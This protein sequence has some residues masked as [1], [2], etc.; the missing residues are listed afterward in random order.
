M[1]ID[2]K[3][4]PRLELRVHQIKM[5]ILR[6]DA[7]SATPPL[8]AVKLVMNL[9]MTEIKQSK[10]CK[11]KFIAISRAQPHSPSRRRVF[12][13]LLPVRKRSDLCGLLLKSKCITPDASG[14]FRSDRHG[15]ID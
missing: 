10:P 3:L 15:H 4:D 1:E 2:L 7:F 5:V 8:E 13:D 6:D 11:V 12:V 9:M 14:E